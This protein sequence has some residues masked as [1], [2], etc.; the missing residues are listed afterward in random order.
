[1]IYLTVGKAWVVG[2]EWEKTYLYTNAASSRCHPRDP[3]KEMSRVGFRK[4]GRGD[5]V[6]QMQ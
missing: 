1:M 6:L 4:T 5:M 2:G 3:S